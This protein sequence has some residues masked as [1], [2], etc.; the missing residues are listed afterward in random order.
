MKVSPMIRTVLM[1]LL[2]VLIAAAVTGPSCSR[3]IQQVVVDRDADQAAA[4]HS[5]PVSLDRVDHSLWDTL[6]ARYVDSDGMVN[7]A[8]WKASDAD[9]SALQQYLANLRTADPNATA[10]KSSKLSF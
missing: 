5:Q 2:V 4:T 3:Q 7:Y 9:R 1:L 6:L 8:A 10:S